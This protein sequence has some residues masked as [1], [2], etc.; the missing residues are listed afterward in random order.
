MIKGGHMITYQLSIFAENKPGRLAAVTQVLAMEKINIRAT[1]I[2]TSD[3]F[4][5]INLIVDDP[6]RAEAALT[7]AGMTVTLNRV[8][9]VIISDQPGGLNKL[10]QLLFEEGININNA[11]GFVLEGSRKAVFVVS[12]DQI[13][14]A[15]R[16]VEK[17]GF[18]TLDAEALSAVEPFHYMKY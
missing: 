17:K 4:G 18:Q 11:Y 5:V 10:T 6:Q 9:A 14:K 1:T 2:A 16:L 7:K 15:E 13:E 8:L 12:V 3:T